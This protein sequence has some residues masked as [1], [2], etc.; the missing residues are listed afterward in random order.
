MSQKLTLRCLVTTLWIGLGIWFPVPELLLDSRQEIFG[1]CKSDSL[2]SSR[3]EIFRLWERLSINSCHL[4]FHVSCMISAC[5]PR[6]DSEHLFQRWRLQSDLRGRLQRSARSRGVSSEWRRRHLV[7]PS[8]NFVAS[9][10]AGIG[11]QLNDKKLSAVPTA[12][13]WKKSMLALPRKHKVNVEYSRQKT[14][15]D[16]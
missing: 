6:T 16:S 10:F 7:R 5:T 15:F 2:Y 1:L 11:E 9:G 13:F 12:R 4:R 8:L 14:P 3:Q